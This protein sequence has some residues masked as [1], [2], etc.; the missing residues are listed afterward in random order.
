MSS[1]EEIQARISKSQNKRQK[2]KEKTDKKKQLLESGRKIFKDNKMVRVTYRLDDYYLDIGLR[3]FKD[4]LVPNSTSSRLSVSYA[5]CSPLD[6]YSH[7]TAKALLGLRTF[8]VPFHPYHFNMQ[9]LP[10]LRGKHKRLASIAL[11]QIKRDILEKAIRVPK[12]L[13]RLVLDED[14][15][16]F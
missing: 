14:M 11:T 13:E 1:Q 15:V 4:S 10:A 6:T 3:E 7:K 12:K 9:M 16:Y 5:F 2:E 8:D